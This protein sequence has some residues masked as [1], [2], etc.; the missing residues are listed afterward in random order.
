MYCARRLRWICRSHNLVVKDYPWAPYG[1]TL[2]YSLLAGESGDDEPNETTWNNAWQF[3]MKVVLEYTGRELTHPFDKLRAIA[4]LASEIETVA[5]PFCGRYMAG[6]WENNLTTGLMW[7]INGLKFPQP[8][9]SRY[10]AP[11]WSW[12]ST[13]GSVSYRED[14]VAQ[15]FQVLSYQFHT[16]AIEPLGA[17]QPGAEL[18]ISA[19]A[20]WAY[21]SPS[22]THLCKYNLSQRAESSLS[23][24]LGFPW[25]DTAVFGTLGWLEVLFVEIGVNR[26]P[27]SDPSL[28]SHTEISGLIL[29]RDSINPDVFVRCGFVETLEVEW[30]DDA[31][32]QQIR[33]R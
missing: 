26:I 24:E 19:R 2:P 23:D 16:N 21:W 12:A 8:R 5:S 11:T 32:V 1:H 30:L 20:K 13:D 17:C 28:G 10:I 31:E 6:L 33:I 15:D 7:Y 18:V 9:P 22:R 3:W 14:V 4:G 27:M 25:P 29:V